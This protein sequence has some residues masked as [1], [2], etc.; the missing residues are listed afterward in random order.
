MKLAGRVIGRVHAQFGRPSG[1]W[2]P[3]VG[4]I[5]ASR[6]SNRRR[7]AWV[8]SLL[9]IQPCDRVLEIGFGP[10]IAI[11]EI[12]RIAVDGY[13][14]GLDHS[15]QMVRQARRRNADAILAGRVDLRLGSVESLPLFA[16]PF[17]KVMAVN[18]MMFWDSPTSRLAQLRR[19]LRAG[20]RIAVAQQPR[21]PG[22]SDATAATRGEE[23]AAALAHAGFCNV[24]TKTLR[25]SPAVVCAIATNPP[26]GGTSCAEE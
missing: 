26:V 12:S 22:A 19:L 23:I 18:T 14:C 8:V 1:F 21:G 2:G 5:M 25:L 16:A 11:R 15:E 17:D 20:G 10:G 3:L 24:R 9:D 4:W 6:S 7:N 13:V